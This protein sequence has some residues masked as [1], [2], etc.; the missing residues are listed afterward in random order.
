[1]PDTPQLVPVPPH[2]NRVRR[3]SRI[4]GIILVVGAALYGICTIP[5]V[6]S[7]LVKPLTVSEQ[8][9]YSD[10]VI[11][12]GGG[13]K[14]DGSVGPIVQ[15]RIQKG[16]ELARAPFAPALL[17]SGGPVKG[18]QFVESVQMAAYAQTLGVVPPV[19][20]EE[21]STS[22]RENALE[23]RIIMEDRPWQTALLVTS[24]FHS[25]RACNVFREL[26]IAV[27]CVAAPERVFNVWERLKLTKGI[28]REYGATIYYKLLGYI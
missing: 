11:V 22:T 25:R 8:P 15:Q 7:L 26:S 10:V 24:E 1:M 9:T 3:W 18:K 13:L 14:K 27:T 28:I 16:V 20:L 17:M 2:R 19:V 21:H 4:L 6:Q 23:S 12:L 5:F